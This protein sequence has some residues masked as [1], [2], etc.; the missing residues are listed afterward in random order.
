MSVC[1]HRCTCRYVGLWR[2]EVNA[3]VYGPDGMLLSEHRQIPA[4]WTHPLWLNGQPVAL[5]RNNTL[6]RIQTDHLRR[7]ESVTNKARQR[8]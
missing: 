1:S 8:M 4:R 6:Y 5:V 3:I 2:E 7:L